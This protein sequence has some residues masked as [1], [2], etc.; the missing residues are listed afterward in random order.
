MGR[1]M[2]KIDKESS[3]TAAP[4][5]EQLV[6]ELIREIRSQQN[7][8]NGQEIAVIKTL[9][10]IQE[11]FSSLLELSGDKGIIKA[12]NKT[13]QIT[14]LSKSGYY[15]PETNSLGIKNGTE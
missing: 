4:E 10:R 12:G 15:I 3:F 13:Y 2:L 1:D 7:I 6:H 9:K 8:L 5:D 11:L 14:C